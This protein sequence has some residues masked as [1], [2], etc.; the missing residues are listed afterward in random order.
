MNVELERLRAEYQDD[1]DVAE[2]P[3]EEQQQLSS[4]TTITR[5]G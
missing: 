5:A 2:L 3:A 1:S 4:P